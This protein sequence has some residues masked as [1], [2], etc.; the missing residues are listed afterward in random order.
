[1]G[2]SCSQIAVQGNGRTPCES[3]STQYIHCGSLERRYKME[4]TVSPAVRVSLMKGVFHLA[5]G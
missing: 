2:R 1:M 4:S 5:C 3:M